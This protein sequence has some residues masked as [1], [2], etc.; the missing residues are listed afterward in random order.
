M[1]VKYSDNNYSQFTETQ[2]NERDLETKVFDFNKSLTTK[3]IIDGDGNLEI[4][5]PDFGYEKYIHDI[6]NWQKQR[7]SFGAEPG[8]YYFKVFFNFNTNYGLLGG[9]MTTIKDSSNESSMLNSINTA[10]GYLKT[11]LH[12]HKKENIQERIL[13]LGKFVATLKDISLRT[14]WM[15]KSLSGINSINSKYVDN[16]DKEKIISIGFGQ[17]SVD[18]RLGTLMDLYKYACFDQI[19]CKEIIPANLRKFEMSIMIYHIPLNNYHTK[20]LTTQDNAKRSTIVGQLWDSINPL[21]PT[22]KF[23][24]VMEAK[25]TQPDNSSDFSNMMSFKLFTFLN[26]EIDCENV[27]E[28]YLDGMSNEQPF[29]LGNNQMKIKYD[30]VYEHRM[31]E[32]AQMFFGSDG[33]YYNEFIPFVFYADDGSED[34]TNMIENF[35]QLEQENNQHSQRILALNQLWIGDQ[36]T[37]KTSIMNYQKMLL[38]KYYIPI[39][40]S[41]YPLDINYMGAMKSN[42]NNWFSRLLGKRGGTY[43]TGSQGGGLFRGLFS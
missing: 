24:G 16:F 35:K 11:I 26:C 39:S 36:W 1:A 38:G 7:V 34:M 2:D 37:G 40:D 42:Y 21:G 41:F 5:L 17:E 31:N 25:K 27:N 6:A 29:Q 8:Y 9:L 20:A 13:A 4:S 12:N 30:R 43:D 28:Y 23:D 19:N 3:P 14:P 15:F 33:F 18:S 32:W 22:L 10:Y